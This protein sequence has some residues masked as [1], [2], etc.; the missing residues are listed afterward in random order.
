MTIMMRSSGIPIPN[1]NSSYG[2][3]D[4]LF[5][6]FFFKPELIGSRFRVQGSRFKVQ[7]LQPM[8]IVHKFDQDPGY[9]T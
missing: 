5:T 7:G 2:E 6:T 4:P 8:D 1:I 9:P 3:L